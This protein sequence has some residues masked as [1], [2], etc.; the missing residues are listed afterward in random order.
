MPASTRAESA[1]PEQITPSLLRG[2]PLPSAGADKLS[3]RRGAGDRWRPAHSG[4]R[5]AA[6]DA[7]LIGPGL[8][9][10][11]ETEALL[12]VW[13]WPRLRE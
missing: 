2:W 9:D 10:I 12:R 5:A 6:A 3:A 11:D 7:L 4:G 1:S 13:R 8:D